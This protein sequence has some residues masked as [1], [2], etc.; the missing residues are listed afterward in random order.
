M[1]NDFFYLNFECPSL[2]ALHTVSLK[3]VIYSGYLNEMMVVLDCC[4][5]AACNK[6]AFIDWASRVF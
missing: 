3:S 5:T 6:V 2:H 1:D 4:Y